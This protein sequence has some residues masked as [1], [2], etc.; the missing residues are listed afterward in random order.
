LSLEITPDTAGVY[1]DGAYAGTV[2]DFSPTSNPLT[3]SPGRHH[4]EIREP[5]FQTMAFDTDVTAGQVIPYQGTM[6][7]R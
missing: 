4:I 5:N 6:Q 3:L 7:P 1:V 2:A